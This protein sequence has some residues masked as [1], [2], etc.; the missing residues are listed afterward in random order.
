M[1]ALSVTVT[2]FVVLST[3]DVRVLISRVAL[4]SDSE[5]V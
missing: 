3:E 5:L 1:V 2:C 4:F